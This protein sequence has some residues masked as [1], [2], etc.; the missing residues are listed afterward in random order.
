LRLEPVRDSSLE[1]TIIPV[2]LVA[3]RD[4]YRPYSPALGR[5]PDGRAVLGDDELE[6][7]FEEGRSLNQDAA[8]LA[9]T[10]LD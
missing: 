3:S 2:A 1:K 4:A 10:S 8:V 6:A 9:L 7:L 5:D